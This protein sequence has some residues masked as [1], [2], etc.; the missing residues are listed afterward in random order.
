[1]LRITLNSEPRS[2]PAPLPVAE[3]LRH[4]GKDSKKLAE[5][6]TGLGTAMRGVERSKLSPEQRL[7]TR[8]W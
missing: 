6:S 8:G 5:V 4:L 1:M 7:S 3:L 2:F